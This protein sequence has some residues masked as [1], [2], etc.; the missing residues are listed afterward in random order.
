MDTF[1]F[2]IAIVLMMLAIQFQQNWLV[3]GI[4]AVLIIT[5][6]SLPVTMLLILAGG[7]LYFFSASMQQYWPLILFG[8]VILSILFG[9]GKSKGA[10]GMYPQDMGMDMGLPPMGGMY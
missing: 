1:T 2:M 8:L 9:V 10:Q 6:K 4:A 7:I 5:T 3:I